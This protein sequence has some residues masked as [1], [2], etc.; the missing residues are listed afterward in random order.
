MIGANQPLYIWK[1]VPGLR[2]TEGRPTRDF[3]LTTAVV[4]NLV[5][6]QAREI[7]D[8]S[9]QQIDKWFAY[10]PADTE[11]SHQD[12]LKDADG[13]T[14]RIETVVARRGPLGTVHHLS[15]QL[16]RAGA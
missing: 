11:V 7:V 9:W 10:L 3:M 14:F 4:G 8:G 6:K 15:C 1:S 13:Q 5:C 16:V 12:L 2:D